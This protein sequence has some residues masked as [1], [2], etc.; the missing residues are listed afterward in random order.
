MTVQ[1]QGS[2]TAKR[3]S[4]TYKNNYTAFVGCA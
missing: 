2:S 4:K 1:S 3:L